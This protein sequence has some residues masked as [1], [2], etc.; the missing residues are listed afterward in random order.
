MTFTVKQLVNHRALVSG[1]DAAGV[2]GQQV[3]DTTQWDSIKAEVAKTKAI[4]EFDAEVLDFFAPLVAASD[5]LEATLEAP[6]EGVY[7]VIEEPVE[8]VEAKPG[9]RARLNSHSVILQLIAEDDTDRLVWVNGEL[10]VL[11]G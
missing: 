2:T 4:E 10:E 1:T 9:R 7:V 5:K 11:K 3:L 6:D 8:G